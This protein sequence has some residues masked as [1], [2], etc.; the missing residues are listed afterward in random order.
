M[1]LRFL[2]SSLRGARDQSRAQFQLSLRDQMV[3]S[4][5]TQRLKRWAILGH[6]YGTRV[7]MNFQPAVDG[8]PVERAA[9]CSVVECDHS[10][11]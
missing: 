4:Y 2:E 5:D 9:V 10:H 3:I 11:Q 1:S 7:G 8:T 6:P